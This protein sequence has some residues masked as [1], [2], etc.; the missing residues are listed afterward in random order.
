[1]GQND[2]S[3]NHCSEKPPQYVRFM[4]LAGASYYSVPNYSVFFLL[5]NSHVP[6]T[7]MNVGHEGGLGTPA[8]RRLSDLRPL[9]LPM[10]RWRAPGGTSKVES[11]IASAWCAPRPRQSPPLKRATTTASSTARKPKSSRMPLAMVAGF[12]FR[13]SR[14]F[15][16]ANSV[17]VYS[18]FLYS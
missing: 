11:K 14:D 4:A 17:Y 9:P 12:P 2:K 1:M 6:V 18:P 7:D 13:G 16:L 15:A 5:L 8:S 10:G 3:Q